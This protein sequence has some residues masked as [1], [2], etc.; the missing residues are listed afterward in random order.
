MLQGQKQPPE[1]GRYPD[2]GLIAFDTSHDGSCDDFRVDG[3]GRRSETGRH[4][5]ADKSRSH[6]LQLHTR[7]AETFGDAECVS[8]QTG[9]RR[10]V[11]EVALTDPEPG[12]R[13]E[14]DD[15]TI[16]LPSQAANH[17]PESDGWP[18]EVDRY[19][20]G[21]PIGLHE[22]RGGVSQQTKG[23]EDE[24]DIFASSVKTSCDCG[25]GLPDI[26]GIEHHGPGYFRAISLGPS[27]RA[28][29]LVFVSPGQHDNT[30][31]VSYQTIENCARDFRSPPEYDDG[32]GMVERI[33]H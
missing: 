3:E 8:V 15:S 17:G 20:L 26:P 11:N 2:D 19:V 9:F 10:S 24:V 25:G 33:I 12:N 31:T 21:N 4:F 28:T 22:I 5:G 23:D 7:T 13:R 29:K 16:T 27:R 18:C 32:L 6:S 30:A 1:G 14:Q